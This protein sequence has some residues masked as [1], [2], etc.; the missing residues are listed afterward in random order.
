MVVIV[1]I[2][3]FM[4]IFYRLLGIIVDLVIIIFGFIIF[5]CLNFIDVIFILLGIVGFIFLFG[6]VVDVNVIIFERIKEELRFG[7]SIRNLIDFGFNKGFIVIFDLN[8]I[9]LIIII[10]LFVFGI[11]L[12]KGFVVILVLG[13]LV[14]MFIVIIVIKVLFLI[15]VNMFGFRSLKFFGVI[16]EEVK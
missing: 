9:I 1:L 15:F 10:I 4:I 6:M 16:V 7:N 11:G 14:L 13:I 8:L 2:W 12:I 3:V 5:V